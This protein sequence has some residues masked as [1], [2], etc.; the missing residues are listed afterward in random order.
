MDNK[1]EG[2]IQEWLGNWGWSNGR[3]VG[4]MDVVGGSPRKMADSAT[5]FS[6][7]ALA[8]YRSTADEEFHAAI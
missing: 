7:A 8:A 4:P 6:L 5:I 2:K 3:L 1:S